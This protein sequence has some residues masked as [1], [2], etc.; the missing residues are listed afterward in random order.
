MSLTRLL[1][2]WPT[3]QNQLYTYTLVMYNWK[4]KFEK[5]PFTMD[6]SYMDNSLSLS[7]KRKIFRHKSSK[8]IKNLYAENYK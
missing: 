8:H 6:C 1:D 7:R 5:N 4:L 3:H 2:I